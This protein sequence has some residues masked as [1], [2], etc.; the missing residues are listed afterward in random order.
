LIQYSDD[1]ARI[2]LFALVRAAG[3]RLNS[4]AEDDQTPLEQRVH[5]GVSEAIEDLI[6]DI[7]QIR[8]SYNGYMKEC[9]RNLSSTPLQNT[10]G[11][12]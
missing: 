6:E 10:L 1:D 11:A 5:L 7:A 9:L 8:F 4:Q 2:G 12:F 3:T